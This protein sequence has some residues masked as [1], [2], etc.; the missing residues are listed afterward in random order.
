MKRLLASKGFVLSV[1]FSILLT[2]VRAEEPGAASRP[3]KGELY[4]PPAK[5]EWEKV[6][7]GRS[8]WDRAKL[9]SALELAGQRKS[10]AV[11][12][13]YRGRLLAERYW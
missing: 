4:F 5:G 2:G 9:E 10:S 6:D 12:I 11:V 3:G 8:G 13:L 1:V 7:P